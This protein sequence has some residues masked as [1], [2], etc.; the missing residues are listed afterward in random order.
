MTRKPEICDLCQ[1]PLLAQDTFYRLA[2]GK[3]VDR[4]CWKK[5]LPKAQRRA[6]TVEPET[7][8]YRAH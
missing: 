6:V 8:K 2:S 4:T 1:Q 3:V 5:L 7:D